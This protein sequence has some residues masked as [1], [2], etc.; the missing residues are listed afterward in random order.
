MY[1]LLDTWAVVAGNK[2]IVEV[3]GSFEDKHNVHIVMELCAGGEL[4]DRYAYTA[5]LQVEGLRRVVG[6]CS[7][8]TSRS[9]FMGMA[10]HPF[11]RQGWASL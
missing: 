11:G 5:L 6:L 8:A 2:N 7:D 3:K 9:P 4:F 10:M 1:P